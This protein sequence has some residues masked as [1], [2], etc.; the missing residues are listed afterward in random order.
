MA[1]LMRSIRNKHLIFL[2]KGDF[3]VERKVIILTRQLS[4]KDIAL[5]R[6]IQH[7]KD[8]CVRELT[9]AADYLEFV[10][11]LT[12]DH[13]NQ[14]GFGEYLI[15]N[16]I[17]ITPSLFHYYLTTQDKLVPTFYIALETDEG[18]THVR[19]CNNRELNQIINE[20]MVNL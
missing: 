7:R 8:N 4:I 16:P 17:N 3:F 15:G 20:S 12:R 18:L 10:V 9:T 2:K 14:N 13:G 1:T 6:Y 19:Q 5:A 11:Q